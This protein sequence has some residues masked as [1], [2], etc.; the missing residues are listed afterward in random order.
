MGFGDFAAAA[1]LTPAGRRTG[2]G[3]VA[4]QRPPRRRRRQGPRGAGGGRSPGSRA[5]VIIDHRNVPRGVKTDARADSD[6]DLE[7]TT[8]YAMQG[9]F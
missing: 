1:P 5:T 3:S 4:V 9:A 7:V 6:V 2:S 8:G